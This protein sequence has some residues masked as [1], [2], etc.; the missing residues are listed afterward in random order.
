MESVL[1]GRMSG[2]ILVAA[3]N[4]EAGIIEIIQRVDYEQKATPALFL[5][6]SLGRRCPLGRSA[7][8]NDT[9]T[10]TVANGYPTYIIVRG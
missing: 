3:A 2:R 4:S 9:T 6:F 7:F 8:T 5:L 10:M 1:G